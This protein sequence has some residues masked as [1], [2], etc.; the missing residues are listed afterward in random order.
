MLKPVPIGLAGGCAANYG[1]V[2]IGTAVSREAQIVRSAA[3]RLS[4]SVEQSLAL[5]GPKAA[6][7]SQIW[8]LARECSEPDW[9]CYGADPISSLA[10]ALAEEFIRA[11]PAAVPLPEFAPEPDGSI[12]LDWA[13]S[14][15]R[16]ITMSAG[17]RSRIAYAWIDGSNTGRGVFKLDGGKVPRPVLSLIEDAVNA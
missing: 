4:G 11:L 6:A 5:F 7:I 8:E 12:S 15:Y 3:D 14:R 10:A 9:D 2:P 17:T 1:Y 16:S 13:A